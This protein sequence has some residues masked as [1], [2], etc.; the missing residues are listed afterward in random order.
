MPLRYGN[1]PPDFV[2]PKFDTR[3]PEE[4]AA[5]LQ[6]KI[7]REINEYVR[8]T[9]PWVHEEIERAKR[10]ELER[11]QIEAELDAEL[12]A[13]AKLS[14]PS[15][16]PIE[17]EEVE[18]VP[19]AQVRPTM[20]TFQEQEQT[21][22]ASLTERGL[23]PNNPTTKATGERPDWK[24]MEGKMPKKV[25]IEIRRKVW[26]EDRIAAKRRSRG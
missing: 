21:Y 10:A 9:A 5:E 1:L 25:M 8:K 26:G 11:Q 12:T 19:L 22:R 15:D 6:A 18:Q 2:W 13:N 23:D 3:T 17:A 4:Q 24:L 16:Q 20:S 14:S 7:V